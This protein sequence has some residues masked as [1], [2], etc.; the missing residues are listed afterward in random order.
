MD[1]FL[2]NTV[3]KS[4]HTGA[5]RTSTNQRTDKKHTGQKTPA[6]DSLQVV[7]VELL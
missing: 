5:G 7:K 1:L 4:N 3:F 2:L 6:N